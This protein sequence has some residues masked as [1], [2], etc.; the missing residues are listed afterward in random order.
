MTGTDKPSEAVGLYTEIKALLDSGQLMGALELAE[1]SLAQGRD[2]EVALFALAATSYRHGMIGN[3][4][5]LIHEIQAN[6]GEAADLHEV[7]AILYCQAGLLPQALYHSKEASIMPADGRMITLFG[8]ELPAFTQALSNIP[9]K[10]LVRSAQAALERGDSA[11]AIVH[12]EQHLLIVPEDVEAIDLYASALMLDGQAGK[13]LGMLR[14]LVTLGGQKPTLLSRIGNCLIAMGRHEQGVANHRAALVSAPSSIALWGSLV[15]DLAY[16]NPARGDV[17][18]LAAGWAECV[19]NIAVKSP[20][21]A[22]Q[23]GQSDTITLAFLCSGRMAA[24]EQEM[25]ARLVGSLDKGRFSTLGLGNGELTAPHNTIYRGLFDRWRNVADLDVL[26]LGA[27]VRGEGVSI[28]LDVDGLRVPGRAGLFLRNSAP[29]QAAWLNAPDLHAVPGATLHLVSEPRGLPGELVVPGG[30]VL[31]DV[32]PFSAGPLPSDALDAG[33]AF[34]VDATMA[35]ITPDTAALWAQVL[36]AVPGSMLLLRDSGQ[37]GESEN[38]TAL[39]ELFGN[40]GVAHRIDV[41]KADLPQFCAQVDVMLAPTPSVNVLDGGRAILSG[42]P[43]VILKDSVATADLAAALS[44]AEVA[45]RMVATDAAGYVELAKGWA[46]DAQS[47]AAFRAN[48]RQ[49][50]A[51]A[52]GMDFA[53]HAQAFAQALAQRVEDLR[54]K[55]AS[56]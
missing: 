31:C 7:L 53:R 56:A 32:V 47:L 27:L 50:L 11:T 26:T 55:V 33:F 5:K 8:P 3:A 54:R 25:L 42:V 28:L 20:R 2:P 37:F 52:V 45:G 13:A 24:I 41:V 6:G 1:A 29:L 48:P 21:P 15:A 46:S 43:M 17:A 38:V 16:F 12:V 10:P 39:I 51:G 22:P 35:Q 14:S 9:H 40:F 4:I 44:G 19:T 49:A 36:A 23:L 34:G 30:R 18:A